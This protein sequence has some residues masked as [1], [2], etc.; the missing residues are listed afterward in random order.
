MPKMCKKFRVKIPAPP[1][2]H[3]LMA[4]EKNSLD[5]FFSKWAKTQI[6]MSESIGT[7]HLVP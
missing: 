5:V 3:F 4:E 7:T 6:E 1:G 2:I